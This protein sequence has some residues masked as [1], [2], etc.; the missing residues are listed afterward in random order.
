MSWFRNRE[1]ATPPEQW[2][3]TDDEIAEASAELRKVIAGRYLFG[4]YGETCPKCGSQVHRTFRV[5]RIQNTITGPMLQDR[6]R[7]S[8]LVEMVFE[9]IDV[10]CL[11]CDFKLG[12]ERPLDAAAAEAGGLHG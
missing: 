10:Q 3:P 4:H 1:P 2:S 11:G 8:W 9:A 7:P 5:G 12:S 6:P